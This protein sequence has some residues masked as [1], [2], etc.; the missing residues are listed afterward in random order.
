MLYWGP[1]GV[2]GPELD[3]E[4]LSYINTLN[5]STEVA[6]GAPVD[7]TDPSAS[8]GS[9]SAAAGSGS[10]FGATSPQKRQDG[11]DHPD[12]SLYTPNEPAYDGSTYVRLSPAWNDGS[13]SSA[14]LGQIIDNLATGSYWMAYKYRVPTYALNNDAC[15]LNVLINN[16][17]VMGPAIPS[18]VDA[19]DGWARAGG[20]FYV[21]DELSGPAYLYFDFYCPPVD[22]KKRQE[23]GDQD[24]SVGTTDTSY[25]EGF[26][27]STYVQP[28]ASIPL[29][30]L[31]Y[32]RMGIDDGGWDEYRSGSPSDTDQDA[33]TV[34]ADVANNPVVLAQT[35]GAG[36]A[37]GAGAAGGASGA[38]GATGAG[39]SGD[40]SHA[41][42]S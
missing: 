20:F 17:P 14:G 12:L 19:T 8:A 28:D 4:A 29:L 9:D 18:L 37:G 21:P 24:G 27:P 10:S 36:S 31:D 42:S 3:T 33:A 41:Q 16:I 7:G 23:S 5:T 1:S 38:S 32:I 35:T 34:A 6:G 22:M 13:D 30:D 40:P 39:G 2:A 11:G 25:P 26:D 15:Q